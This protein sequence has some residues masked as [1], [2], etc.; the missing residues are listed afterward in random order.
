[1]NRLP[2]L[3]TRLDLEAC[4]LAS[5]AC[6]EDTKAQL[7]SALAHLPVESNWLEGLAPICQLFKAQNGAFMAG[8]FAE[9]ASDDL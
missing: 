6:D 1:M 3:A 8:V 7:V 2:L 4:I 9:W 5:D